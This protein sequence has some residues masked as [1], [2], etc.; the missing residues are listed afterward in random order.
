MKTAKERKRDSEEAAK[1]I[2]GEEMQNI[3]K[4]MDDA[5]ARGLTSIS[6]NK[7]PSKAAVEILQHHGYCLM[8]HSSQR[9]GVDLEISWD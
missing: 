7:Y 2:V 4:L 6:V 9:E 3:E 8:D 1:V 5:S